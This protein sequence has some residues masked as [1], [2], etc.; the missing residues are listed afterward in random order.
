[1]K[2]KIFLTIAALTVVELSAANP[3]AGKD[4]SDCKYSNIGLKLNLGLGA[5]DVA[6]SQNLERGDAASLSLGYGVSQR[7]TVWLGLDVARHAHEQ[8]QKLD[9]GF[10]GVEIGLQYKLRPNKKFRPYGAIGLGTF[11]LGTEETDTLLN[12][13]GVTWA[14]GA[15][16]RLLRFLSVGAEFFWKDFDYTQI[17]V[18]EEEDFARLEQPIS[19][20]TNGFLV[21]FTLH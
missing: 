7:V 12:G 1:M 5:Q 6:S 15:E 3:V 2:V 9:S 18:G 4:S 13:S 10:L 17:R 20:N 8:F 16:Y 21:K 19:G 11:F 14:L